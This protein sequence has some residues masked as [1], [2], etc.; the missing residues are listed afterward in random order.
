MVITWRKVALVLVVAGFALWTYF[1]FFAAAGKTSTEDLPRAYAAGNPVALVELKKRPY[2]PVL[3][4]AFRSM[5]TASPDA[6]ARE[7]AV[8]Y[9]AGGTEPAEEGVIISA[10][11]D[12]DPK[13][14]QAAC[15]AARNRRLRQAVD[16]LI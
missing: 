9:L 1:R 6:K 4:P 10:L 7:A 11:G 16:V 14:R 2:D 12:P 13:V 3:S 15:R 5:A 8:W